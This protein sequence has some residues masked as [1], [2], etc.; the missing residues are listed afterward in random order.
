[1][2]RVDRSIV[3]FIIIGEGIEG[4][5]RSPR[6]LPVLDGLAGERVIR[7]GRCAHS[8]GIAVI[9]AFIGVV[10]ISYALSRGALGRGVLALCA[11]ASRALARSVLASGA[12]TRCAPTR[13]LRIREGSRGSRAGNLRRGGIHLSLASAFIAFASVMSGGCRIDVDVA[14]CRVG[15]SSGGI[16]TSGVDGVGGVGCIG[17]VRRVGSAEVAVLVRVLAVVSV[18][19][20]SLGRI[21]ELALG[22]EVF[23]LEVFELVFAEIRVMLHDLSSSMYVPDGRVGSSR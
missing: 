16:R 9:V 1:M 10:A 8:A 12:A 2:I 18:A 13:G 11:R 6:I 22:I 7:H 23:G 15:A 14:V 20:G 17:R 19:V 5:R 3:V 21:S 4:Y